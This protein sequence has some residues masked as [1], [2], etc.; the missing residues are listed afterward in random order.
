MTLKDEA[1]KMFERYHL[2]EEHLTKQ[3]DSDGSKLMLELL[4]STSALLDILIEYNNEIIEYY[5]GL[6]QYINDG[7]RTKWQWRLKMQ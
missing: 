5:N 3:N 1:K 2:L 4:E 7:D 6:I